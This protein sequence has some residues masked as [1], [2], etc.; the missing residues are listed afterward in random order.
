MIP[1]YASELDPGALTALLAPRHPGVRVAAFEVVEAHE[2]TN[3]HARLRLTYDEPAGAP[4][5]LFCKLLPNDDRRASVAASGMGIREAWFYDRLAHRIDLRV[6]QVHA[7]ETNDQDEFLI[8]L[9][10]LKT[11]GCTVS[12]GTYG[13][14][15]DAMAV[16]LD[17]LAQLHV[18]YED[19]ARRADEAPWVQPPR[20]TSDYGVGML[21]YGL[22]HHRDKLDDA[23]AEIAQLYVDDRDAL[24]AVWV[25]GPQTIIHGDPHLGNVFDDHG[26]IGFL[27]WGIMSVNTPMRDVSYF[28][29]MALDVEDRRAHEAELLRHYLEVRTALG[30]SPIDF[31]EAWLRHRAH[32]AY[33]VP[34]SC[35]IVLFPENV[36]EARRVFAAAFLEKAQ[37][38][39]EDLDARDALRRLGV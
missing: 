6:P 27:D 31:D 12:D 11:N 21:R 17:G 32:A 22:E 28:M 13:V 2:V 36:S 18:R 26:T 20:R 8:L 24:Q 34:A 10:D 7:V 39:V 38:C 14:T 23:F 30:G 15:P 1:R 35:Q 4:E 37:R 33:T 5:H 16:A 3:S 19:P 25:Q 9:E 29:T